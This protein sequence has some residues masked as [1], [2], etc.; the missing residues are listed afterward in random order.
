MKNN[1]S[2]TISFNIP[3]SAKIKSERE[4]YDWVAENIPLSGELDAEVDVDEWKSDF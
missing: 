1:Y 2:V 3:R 4:A